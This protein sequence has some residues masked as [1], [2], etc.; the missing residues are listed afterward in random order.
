M[1]D[2]FSILFYDSR[3]KFLQEMIEAGL[4]V[5]TEDL[6]EGSATVAAEVIFVEHHGAV[7]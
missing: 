3:N 4:E 2:V 1:L 7:I 6:A 5:E